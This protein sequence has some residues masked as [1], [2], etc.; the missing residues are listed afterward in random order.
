MEVL[1][2]LTRAELEFSP[3]MAPSGVEE[4]VADPFCAAIVVAK[5]DATLT[6]GGGGDEGMVASG[7]GAPLSVPAVSVAACGSQTCG[8][9]GFCT[10]M[11]PCSVGTNQIH[12]SNSAAD[13]V[14]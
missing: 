3:T 2:V 6:G 9:S 8:G 10:S 12:T 14:Q 7:S 11:Q 1:L 5:G 13:A 4:G